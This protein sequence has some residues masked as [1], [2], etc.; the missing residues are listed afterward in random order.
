MGGKRPVSVVRMT[1][2]TSV[3]SRNAS[4]NLFAGFFMGGF[5]CSTHRLQS[6]RR[7]D[8]IADTRHDEFC[9]QDYL[10]LR[11]QRIHVA[12][13]GLRWH[14]IEAAP[15]RFDFSSAAPM[16]AAARRRSI[17]ILWD[18][19]HYGWPDFL[20]PFRPEFVRHYGRFARQF[21][22]WISEEMDGPFFIA[23]INE[24]S[25]LSWA[26]GDEPHLNPYCRGRGFELKAQLVRA[27][28]E[29]ME[30][31]WSV[32]PSARFLHIDPL[33]HI[34]AD[35][36]RPEEAPQAEGYRWA[37]YQ[38]LDM[39]SGRVWPQLGGD[40][41]YLDIIGLN[42]YPNNQWI[43]RGPAL[44]PE[45][46][47]YRPLRDLIAEVFQRYHRPMF[48][49]ETGAEGVVRPAW[50][51]YVC[52]EVRAALDAGLPVHGICL[53]PI[54]DHPGWVDERHCPNGL[55]DYPAPDGHRPIYEPLA[56]ELAN[57]RLL[58]EPAEAA[59]QPEAGPGRSHE[60]RAVL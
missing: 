20:D 30:A 60:F 31:I 44:T 22:R 15:G 29:G 55:W 41:K 21:A 36:T 35:P 1:L 3:A 56:R 32:L 13:E 52:H 39:V 24:I 46:P 43:Y 40:E 19:C 12:R 33:I 10:R 25:F 16:V 5:E 45:H 50:L 14:L 27:A 53:Y 8:M 58:F 11:N 54:V 2:P 47:S 6:G 23:P 18:I 38:A 17:Q 42:Y 26:G 4:L 9:D 37:Q 59:A 49:A 48:I 34:V 7:L 57:L 28:V 51:R